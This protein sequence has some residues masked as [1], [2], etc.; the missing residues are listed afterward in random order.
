MLVA[1]DLEGHAGNLLCQDRY[2]WTHS[3]HTLPYW[4][5]LLNMPLL[6]IACHIKHVAA[7]GVSAA[8][9]HCERWERSQIVLLDSDNLD[10]ASH[11]SL[12]ATDVAEKRKRTSWTKCEDQKGI[13][14]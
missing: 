6:F 4:R 7:L 8:T 2:D 3:C 11:I 10:E 1:L 9:V 14:S 13:Q 5:L 12:S